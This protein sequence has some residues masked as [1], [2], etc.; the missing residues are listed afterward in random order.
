ML[1]ETKLHSIE[2]GEGGA[3]FVKLVKRLLTPEGVRVSEEPHRVTIA[4]GDDVDAVLAAN[5][6]HLAAMEVKDEPEMVATY[7]ALGSDRVA[8]IK[9]VVAD[10]RA[11]PAR[12]RVPANIRKREPAA[13]RTG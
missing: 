7:P 4:P 2:F 10:F 11:A 3:V 13:R 9:A 12:E 5:F 6:N 1:A 8:R